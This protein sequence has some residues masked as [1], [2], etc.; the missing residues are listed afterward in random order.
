MFVHS[1]IANSGRWQICWRHWEF[2]SYLPT[3]V[4]DGAVTLKGSYSMRDWRGLFKKSLRLT[5]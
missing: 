4:R 3:A 1:A 2:V 5:F